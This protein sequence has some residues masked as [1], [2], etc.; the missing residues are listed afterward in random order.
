MQYSFNSSIKSAGLRRVHVAVFLL[1]FIP[2]AVAAAT[3]INLVEMARF[4]W[5]AL[6]IFTKTS[7]RVWANSLVFLFWVVSKIIKENK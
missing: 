2:F 1:W 5:S 6:C 7:L 4:L 3:V